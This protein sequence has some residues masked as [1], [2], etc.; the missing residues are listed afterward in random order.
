MVKEI[1]LEGVCG[2][3]IVAGKDR[4]GR[5]SVFY[6]GEAANI[7]SRLTPS[8]E[9][10]R[11]LSNQRAFILHEWPDR[12][13][14]RTRIAKEIRFI[15]AAQAVG[16]TLINSRIA[17]NAAAKYYEEEVTALNEVRA[18]LKGLP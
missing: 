15:C 7:Y 14:K 18:L 2:V 1:P 11:K 13:A 8:H 17:T 10:A 4:N 5:R 9:Y 16:M 3:Y 12:A 6:I